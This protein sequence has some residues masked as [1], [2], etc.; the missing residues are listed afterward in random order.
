MG[1][2]LETSLEGFYKLNHN[3]IDFKD[4]AEL[5]LNEYLEGEFRYGDA[6]SYGTELLVR[7]VEGRLNGWVSYTWSR[8]FRKMADIN[9]GKAYPASY[10]KPHDISIVMN[11]EISKKFMLGANW[12][13]TTGSPVTFPTGRFQIGQT[14][15]PVYSDRNA[16]RL[17][18]Y[19]RLDLSLTYMPSQKAG[20][21]WHSEWTSCTMPITVKI[22]G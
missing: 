18:D 7:L 8:T 12:V 15:A 13:Y 6:W 21:K 1:G 14:I 16:Y 20:R 17:P 9:N 3:A 4:H 22:R 5:L 11:Y 2:N 19:H 10:D